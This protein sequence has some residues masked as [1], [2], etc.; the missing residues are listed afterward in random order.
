VTA[1]NNSIAGSAS[2]AGNPSIIAY[3][4]EGDPINSG[5]G[6]LVPSNVALE[7]VFSWY[8]AAQPTPFFVDIPGVATRIEQRLKS[9]HSDAFSAGVS[10]QLGSRMSARVDFV[11]RKFGNF[12]SKRADTNTGLVFDDFG[13]PYDLK[14][15]ENATELNRRYQALNVQ[16]GYQDSAVTV[17][18]AYT[19]SRL[20]GNVDG[21]NVTSGPIPD[22]LALYP[23]Y[24]L[25]S[26]Y[27]PEGDLSADQRH[28]LRAWAVYLLP[29]K[30]AA[31][32]SIAALQTAQ[33]GTPYGAVGTAVVSP[34]VVNPGYA[35]PPDTQPYFFTA[36]DAFH[37]AASYRTDLQLNV[38]RTIPGARRA[39]IFAHFE[40]L[41]LFNKFQA[42]RN[43]GN[44]I[45]TTVLTA[46]DDSDLQLFNPF[47]DT[48]VEGVHWR[49]GE[50]FGQPIS[51]DAYTV[52]R[53]F[54]FS[55]GVKF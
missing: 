27:A 20:W 13:Q 7:R 50:E 52:P 15:I 46:V 42:F 29:W 51:R 10:Q 39:E 35:F 1:Q 12:Y 55:I 43:T 47:T 36:R 30:D 33:S 40:V 17:G 37:T 22:D 45:N 48:P 25:K 38:R 53:T 32:I 14:V 44:Q 24:N 49:K 26:W 18:A 34:F 28:R 5:G 31:E 23:E 2:P 19:L 54:S 41:N 3:F 21:E 6:P 8:N 9:P 16:A 4:Y 11:A